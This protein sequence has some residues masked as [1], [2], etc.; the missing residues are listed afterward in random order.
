MYTTDPAKEPSVIAFAEDWSDRTGGALFVTEFGATEFQVA[1][2]TYP[3]G[4]AVKVVGGNVA[5]AP[6]EALLTVEA[7]DGA[8][9]VFLKVWPADQPE[10]PD[11]P[12]D[13]PEPPADPDDDLPGRGSG[14][15]GPT[16]APAAT[17]RPSRATF[18]G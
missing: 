10:P 9:E 2:R 13:Q 7:D 6:D 1:S 3:T 5:S 14:P 17:A 8:G 18:T 16:S 4:Y 12:T 11:D 15:T